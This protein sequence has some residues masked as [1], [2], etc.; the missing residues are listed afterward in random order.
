M[1]FEESATAGPSEPPD[2]DKPGVKTGASSGVDPVNSDDDT[3]DTS[4][5]E[6][7]FE[8]EDDEAWLN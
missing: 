2:N 3:N 5:G 8:E 6:A 7:Q 4:A 1:A